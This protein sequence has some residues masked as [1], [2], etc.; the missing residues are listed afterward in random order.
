MLDISSFIDIFDQIDYYLLWQRQ[1]YDT[2]IGNEGKNKGMNRFN[3]KVRTFHNQLEKSR[4]FVITSFNRN[5]SNRRLSRK[6]V[7]NL[8]SK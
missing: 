3:G 6:R 7:L 1:G 4:F 8:I 2:F 5:Q